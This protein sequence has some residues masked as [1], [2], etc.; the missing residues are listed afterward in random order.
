MLIEPGTVFAERWVIDGP[1][2]SGSTSE[3]F[4]GHDQHTGE[5]AAIKV[6]R[7]D[8]ADDAQ[9]VQRFPGKRNDGRDHV[10][11]RSV[12]DQGGDVRGGRERRIALQIDDEVSI[13]GGQ[14]SGGAAA[15][16]S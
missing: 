14:F 16:G 8:F 9:S 6:L 12:G 10:A 1:L 13:G 11:A 4:R 3:V 2:A 15:V 5:P 7:P